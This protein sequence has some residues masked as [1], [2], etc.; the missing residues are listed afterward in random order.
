MDK[1]EGIVSCVISVCLTL[2]VS[3][4]IISGGQCQ[5]EHDKARHELRKAAVEK[6][7]VLIGN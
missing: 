7:A 4:L 3:I 5:K 1:V 6:G 2:V